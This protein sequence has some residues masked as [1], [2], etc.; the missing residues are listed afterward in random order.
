VG[1]RAAAS[2]GGG[3]SA[4][5]G[6]MTLAA[7]IAGLGGSRRP[8]VV[9]RSREGETRLQLQGLR[10]LLLRWKRNENSTLWRKNFFF[11]SLSH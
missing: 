11:S 4:C 6:G 5:G 8:A 7:A 9:S 10:L 1:L 3:G 2:G